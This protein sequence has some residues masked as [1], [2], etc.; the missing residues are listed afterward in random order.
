MVEGIQEDALT[1]FVG[2]LHRFMLKKTGLGGKMQNQFEFWL[3]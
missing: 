3:N 2:Y 1:S